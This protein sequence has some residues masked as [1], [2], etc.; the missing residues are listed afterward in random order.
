M[1]AEN[2]DAHKSLFAFLRRLKKGWGRSR[3]LG[4]WLPS[5]A[6]AVDRRKFAKKHRG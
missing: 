6:N 3:D 4:G 1:A 5:Q 2:K